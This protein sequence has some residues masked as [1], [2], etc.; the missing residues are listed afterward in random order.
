LI[1]RDLVDSA[2]TVILRYGQI[3]RRSRQDRD[4]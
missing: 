3:G 2:R 1:W 4:G